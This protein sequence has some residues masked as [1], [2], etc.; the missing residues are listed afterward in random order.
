MK[1]RESWVQ[2]KEQLAASAIADADIE[3]EVILRHTLGAERAQYFAAL[4][5]QLSGAHEEQVSRWIR[6]RIA[7]E[8]LA[9][10]LGHREFYGLDFYVNSSVLIPR[11]ETELLVDKVLECSKER[12]SQYL[13]VGDVG[14]GS[15]AIAVAVARHLPKA[16]IY[17]IDS[18]HEALLVANSNRRRHGVAGRVHL[19][20]GDLLNG[21]NAPLDVIV[22]NP[23][24]LRSGEIVALPQEIRREPVRAL[25]GGPNGL[26]IIE[27]LIRQAPFRIRPGGR[28]LLEV[29][30]QQLESV[31]R[32]GREVFPTAQLSFAHDLSGAARVV[33]IELLGAVG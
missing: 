26:E 19:L 13:Q 27:R 22:S 4:N 12:P 1:I 20:Q 8:P 16:T 32:I 29:A 25:D 28:V 18:S 11:Q 15:G 21:L 10:I 33:S 24:Y 5:D 30:P 14:T 2:A 17:A 3:A 7:G 31:L 23:P 9:Y 6:R